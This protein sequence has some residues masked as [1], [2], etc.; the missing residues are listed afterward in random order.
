MSQRTKWGVPRSAAVRDL[1]PLT[2]SFPGETG[3]AEAEPITVRLRGVEIREDEDLDFLFIPNKNDVI[4]VSSFQF[5][6]QPP[7]Q[8]LHYM[9]KGVDL[10]RVVPIFKDV[11]FSLD[12][13]AKEYKMLTL[14]IQVYDVDGMSDEMIADVSAAATSAAKTASV[15][16][17]QL[18]LVAA[19]VGLALPPLLKLISNLNNH[20][21][22]ID[23]SLQLEIGPGGLRDEVLQPGYFICFKRP[24]AEGLSLDDNLCVTK[25]D[26]SEFTDCSYAVFD[27]RRE[28]WSDVATWAID[29]KMAKL[30]AELDGKGQSDKAPIDYLTETLTAYSKWQNLKRATEI[31]AIPEATRTAAQK[32]LLTRLAQDADVARYLS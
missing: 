17:P 12:G 21:K 8:R 19:G 26:G 30:V 10:G 2:Q 31:K 24:Q 18:G 14:R 28:Y 29:Q 1:L 20:D 25:S 27:I 7:V 3:F 16:F 13:L 32:D 22:I 4:I 15:L 6:S 9:K 11:V 23:E 5:D